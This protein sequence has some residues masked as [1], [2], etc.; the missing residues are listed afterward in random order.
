LQAALNRVGIRHL[1]L[2][3][4]RGTIR[5]LREGIELNLGAIGKGYALDRE[6]AEL[7]AAGVNDFLLHGGQSSVLARGS[8][9]G[10]GAGWIVGLG[11][12]LR[13]DRRLAEIR[14]RD[15]A[16]ATSGASHQFFRSQGKR[17]GHI[18]D[19]RTGWPAEG[20]FS[21]TVLA[22]SA[23]EAD[24]LST[25]FYT[26]GVERAYEY[27]REHP[28]IGMVLLHPGRGASSVEVATAGLDERDFR[29]LA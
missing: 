7:C 6:A 20:V 2:D 13:P 21:S 22:P 27:C 14:L 5:F 3:G 19:P 1:V 23:A 28:Q 17:Y 8:H 29:R 16:L 11:D 18:L 24:A 4:T 10:T 26:L 15:R 9:A 12:P 25:A